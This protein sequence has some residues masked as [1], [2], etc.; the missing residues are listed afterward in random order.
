MGA[1][2]GSKPQ[3]PAPIP[4]PPSRSDKEIQNA[5]LAARQRRAA[6]TGRSETI[7]TGGAGVTE[8]ADTTII[9]LL[10]EG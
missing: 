5:A 7:L 2:F 4:E 6:A 9:T 1:L 8:K 3:T 10:G